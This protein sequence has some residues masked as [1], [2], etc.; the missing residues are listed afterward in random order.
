MTARNASL[1]LAVS[2]VA[3][4]PWDPPMM[5]IGIYKGNGFEIFQ[6]GQ[7]VCGLF[8][9]TTDQLLIQIVADFFGERTTVGLAV[10]AAFRHQNRVTASGQ[11]GGDIE[12]G[13][14]QALTAG[15]RSVVINHHRKRPFALRLVQVGFNPKIAAWVRD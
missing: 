5:A 14:L 3:I 6:A 8:V 9:K 12:E 11:H 2:T 4:P 15:T 7:H 10:T 1:W 13:R